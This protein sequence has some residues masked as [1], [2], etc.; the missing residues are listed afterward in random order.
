MVSGNRPGIRKRP[1]TQAAATGAEHKRPT[2]RIL[3]SRPEPFG[4]RTPP[5][6]AMRPSRVPAGVAH[7][8]GMTL[9]DAY[10]EVQHPCWSCNSSSSSA[11]APADARRWEP[12]REPRKRDVLLPPRLRRLPW[13]RG[14][15]RARRGSNGGRSPGTCAWRGRRGTGRA[16]CRRRAAATGR[17]P[18][19]RPPAPTGVRMT[20]GGACAV[21]R[22]CGRPCAARG[23]RCSIR[24]STG[25]SSAVSAGTAGG[26]RSRRTGTHVLRL[27]SPPAVEALRPGIRPIPR[28]PAPSPTSIR[29][30]RRSS[31]DRCEHASLIGATS[32]RTGYPDNLQSNGCCTFN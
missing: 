14:R 4:P 5:Y 19:I 1:W 2:R 8:S 32:L 12:V 30:T 7:G 20:G 16:A 31:S 6:A 23:R 28:M 24:P 25:P 27:A 18:A 13:P 17:D 26:T 29:M 3:R 10:L 22:A 9:P 15:R 21:W 11:N